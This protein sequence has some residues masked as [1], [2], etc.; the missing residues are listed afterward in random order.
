MLP[1]LPGG[2]SSY[3]LFAALA[4]AAGILF[5]YF[6]LDEIG[7]TFK[8]LALYCMIGSLFCVISAK[9]VYAISYLPTAGFSLANFFHYFINGGIV[10]YGGLLGVILGIAVMAR[11]QHRSSIYLLDEVAPA[12]PLFHAI[13]RFGCLF[14]GCCYGIPWH[15]G[16]TMAESPDV[17][18]FPVQITESICNILIFSVLLIRAK[19]KKSFSGSFRMYMFSYASCR[20]LL[21][22]LRGDM[23]RGIWLWGLSTSQI[24]ALLI[25]FTIGRKRPAADR[26]GET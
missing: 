18:R 14:G 12:F 3:A 26:L 23:D 24:I 20:F 10:F 21:E 8:E 2:I 13:A 16:V 25:M 7:L 19:R 1:E 17:I 11:I 9:A 6:R 15:W 4:M 5:I 22:F